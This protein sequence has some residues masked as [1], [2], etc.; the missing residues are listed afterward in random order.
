MDKLKYCK[1]VLNCILVASK[2]TSAEAAGA[3]GSKAEG[4][5]GAGVDAGHGGGEVERERDVY[6][7]VRGT[8]LASELR[9]KASKVSLR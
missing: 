5:A 2:S 7:P 9:A 6:A 4:A 3:S 1:E 8:A